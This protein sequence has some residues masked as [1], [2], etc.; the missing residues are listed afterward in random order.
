MVFCKC[1]CCKWDAYNPLVYLFVKVSLGNQEFTDVDTFCMIIF[2]FVFKQTKIKINL[3]LAFF[4]NL[5]K[6]NIF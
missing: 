2:N 1:N 3:Q 6:Y 4:L 5:S